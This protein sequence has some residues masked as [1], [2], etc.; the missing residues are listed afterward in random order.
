MWMG[1]TLEE[2]YEFKT[3]LDMA[4]SDSSIENDHYCKP[5]NPTTIHSRKVKISKKSLLTSKLKQGH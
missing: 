2:I 1:Q 4:K 5:T 3:I